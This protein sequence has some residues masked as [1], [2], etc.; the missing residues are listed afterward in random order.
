MQSGQV[1]ESGFVGLQSCDKTCTTSKARETRH[2]E[3]Q[4]EKRP[5]NRSLDLAKSRSS[6]DPAGTATIVIPNSCPRRELFRP[7]PATAQTSQTTPP[8][9]TQTQANKQYNERK[10]EADSPNPSSSWCSHYQ[11]QKRNRPW[12]SES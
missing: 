7:Q 9:K 10:S 5:A 3:A 6:Q 4:S 11:C 8:P 12:S 2:M 1:K